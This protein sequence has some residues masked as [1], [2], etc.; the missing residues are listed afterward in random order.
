M[1]VTL[2]NLR[3]Q[4]LWSPTESVGLVPDYLGKPEVSDLQVPLSVY[5]QV[6]WL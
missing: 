4:V 3:G 2:D 6:L 1:A 5:E